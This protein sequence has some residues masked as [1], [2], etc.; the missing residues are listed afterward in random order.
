MWRVGWGAGARGAETGLQRVE[1][2]TKAG[3]AA[4]ML[5]HEAQNSA[6]KRTSWS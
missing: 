6:P 5:G 4:G 1:R 3:E 2:D